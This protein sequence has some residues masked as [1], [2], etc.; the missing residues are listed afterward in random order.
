MQPTTKDR[1][2]EYIRVVFEGEVI[3]FKSNPNPQ[4][5]EQLKFVAE[6]YLILSQ[7]RKNPEQLLTTTYEEF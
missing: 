2:L 5:F 3:N 6:D 1:V 4:T 7:T